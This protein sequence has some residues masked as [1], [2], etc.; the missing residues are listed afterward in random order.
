MN[1]D[2]LEYISRIVFESCKIPVTFLDT[3][4][5]IKI[6]F[7]TPFIENPINSN[8][9]ELFSQLLYTGV[10][11]DFPVIRTTNYLENYLVI[12]IETGSIIAGPCLYNRMSEDVISGIMNDYKISYIYKNEL[13]SYYQELPIMNSL[14]FMHTGLLLYYLIFRKKLDIGEVLHQN[15]II[16]NTNEDSRSV[17]SHMTVNR[18]NISFHHDP[19]FENLFLQAIKEGRKEILTQYV[20][21]NPPEGMGVLSKKSQLRNEKNLAICGIALYTRAAIDG[22]LQ[23]ELAY[24]MSDLYIQKVEELSAVSDING[25]MGKAF[26][27]FC[28]RVQKRKQLQYSKPVWVC[29]DYIFN[30]IYEKIT[31]ADLAEIVYLNPAYLS[32]LF[33]KELGMPLND[34]I[35]REKVEEAKKLLKDSTHTLPEICSLLNFNDQSY[36]IKIFKKFTGVTPK[37]FKNGQTKAIHE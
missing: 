9:K 35:Q 32:R 10:T 25:L 37:Q 7:P 28:D 16:E 33:K 3:N 24:T 11:S 15:A 21:L 6:K 23:P 27:E 5:E 36:F 18:Q 31:I 8:K 1:L 13:I 22:G 14:K 34:Y 4:G 30:H 17:E 20:A 12:T 2:E 29:Q 26:I 19:S